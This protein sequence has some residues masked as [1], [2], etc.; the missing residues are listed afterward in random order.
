MK[1]FRIW[2]VILM[3]NALGATA[4]SADVVG[5]DQQRDLNQ[6]QRIERGLKSGELSTKEAGELEREQ[7]RVDKMEAHDLKNGSMS[8]A[9]QAKL[10][11]A[12]N[13][14]SE[15]IY[16]QKHDAQLGNPDS[17]SSERMQTDVEQNVNQQQRIERGID[18]GSLTD[19][20]AG[21]LE[22][23]QS[24]VDRDEANAAANGRVGANEQQSVQDAEA[25]QSTRVF[26]K[27][28]NDH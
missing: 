22:R 27:K 8:A 13:K 16:R 6:Q 9:E 5:S 21:A 20:E 2:S 1:S 23:G 4:W 15:D 18:N 17:T 24:R 11:A 12:E 26:R 7:D 10:E 19:R 25:R 28:H 3:A 14:A